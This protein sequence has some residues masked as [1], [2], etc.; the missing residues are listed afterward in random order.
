MTG[1]NGAHRICRRGPSKPNSRLLGLDVLV[2]TSDRKRC[3]DVSSLVQAQARG[4]RPL[5]SRQ[6]QMDYITGARTPLVTPSVARADSVSCALNRQACCLTI[7][8]AIT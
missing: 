8:A 4:C 7:D 2:T 3:C 1:E 6:R 5:E